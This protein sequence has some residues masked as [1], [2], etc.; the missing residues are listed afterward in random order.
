MKHFSMITKIGG[1]IV[2]RSASGSNEGI[3][4]RTE[5]QTADGPAVLSLTP[6][7]A[8]ELKKELETYLRLRGAS[9]RQRESLIGLADSQ[10]ISID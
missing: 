3:P 2:E 9:K 10:T 8:A 5:V 1:P 7:A 4:F 6:N